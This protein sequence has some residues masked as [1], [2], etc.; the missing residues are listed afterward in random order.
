MP[1]VAKPIP[2]KEDALHIAVWHQIKQRIHPDVIAY[3]CPNGGHRSKAQAAKFK[4]QGVISGVPDLIFLWPVYHQGIFQTALRGGYVELK[5][6]DGKANTTEHQDEFMRRAEKIGIS[7]A[8]CRTEDEVFATLK[9]WEV[10][11]RFKGGWN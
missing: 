2:P 4:A 6:N 3:H 11:T 9:K 8:V 7:T 1:K 10:P 5:R